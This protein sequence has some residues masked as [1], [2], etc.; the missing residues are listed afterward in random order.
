MNTK[1]EHE[2]SKRTEMYTENSDSLLLNIDIFS[3]EFDEEDE[4]ASAS[5]ADTSLNPSP[6][7][8]GTPGASSS[9]NSAEEDPEFRLDIDDTKKVSHIY[10]VK[11]NSTITCEPVP[12]S[13][14][15]V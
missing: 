3:A 15:L 1:T 9:A 7:L 4:T 8:E 12:Q 13:Y 5:F 10:Q 6:L 11:E 2:D 14:L